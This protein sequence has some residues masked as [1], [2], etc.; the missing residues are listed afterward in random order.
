MSVLTHLQETVTA[1][2]IADWERI[3]IDTSIATLSTK[4]GNHFKN[5]N[6]KFVFGSYE[7]RTILRRSKDANSDVDYMVVFYNTPHFS[8]R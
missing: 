2:Q 7:R 5:L 3:S 8:D 4:L 6:S 1:V